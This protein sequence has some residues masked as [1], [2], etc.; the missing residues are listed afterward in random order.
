MSVIVEFTV[1]TDEFLFGST[2]TAN[3]DVAVSLEEIIP[4]DATTIPYFWATGADLEA[5]ERRALADPHIDA[6]TQFDRID[7]SALYRVDWHHD[8]V[9]L[10]EALVETGAVV[11]E[12][13]SEENAEANRWNFRV[14]FP[15]HDLLGQFYNVCTDHGIAITIG[16]VY[17]LTE[18]SRA[19][20]AFELTPDQREALVLAVREGYFKVPRE[21]DL[22]EIAAELGI[23]QQ[24]TSKRIRR[25]A[26]KVLRTSLLS[27]AEYR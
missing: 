12:A 17:T 27:P 7:D 11:L 3:C 5:F 19:G 21:T 8:D 9:G 23:S 10:L 16:R 25:G 14:R 24:A 26:D 20:R 1:P 13:Y 6:I 15:N 18:A 2:L 22:G 4:T